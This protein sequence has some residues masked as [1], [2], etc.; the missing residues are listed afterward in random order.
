MLVQIKEFNQPE[1]VR[2]NKPAA[3]FSLSYSWV[4]K[5][6]DS[7]LFELFFNLGSVH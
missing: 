4:H 6:L 2:Y 5:Y 7:E 3:L 1:S